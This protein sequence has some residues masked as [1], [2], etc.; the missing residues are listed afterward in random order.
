[1]YYQ[2]CIHFV[3]NFTNTENISFKLFFQFN[4]ISKC[5]PIFHFILSIINIF[6]IF[7][8]CFCVIQEQHLMF[9]FAYLTF[10]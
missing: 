7:S 6:F 9:Y 4:K 10:F 8:I 1:M 3:F 5:Q 2:K